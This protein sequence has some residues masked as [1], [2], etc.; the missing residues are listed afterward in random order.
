MSRSDA[1]S[2][3]DVYRR[4]VVTWYT[5]LNIMFTSATW[6]ATVL[7]YGLVVITSLIYYVALIHHHHHHQPHC[8]TPPNLL[9]EWSRSAIL[10]TTGISIH[11]PGDTGIIRLI[12]LHSTSENFGSFL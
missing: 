8:Q 3:M 12:N 11:S 5:E 10:S 7:I 1:I 4:K 9:L 6:K 2:T